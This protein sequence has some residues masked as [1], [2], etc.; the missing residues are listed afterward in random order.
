MSGP[1][2]A[3]R[4]LAKTAQLLGL[5]AKDLRTQ[6]D[7]GKTLA[8]VAEQQGVSRDD[9]IAS[10]KEGLAAGAPAG[11]STPAD[12]DLDTIAAN[13]ADGKRP[14]PPPSAGEARCNPEQAVASLAEV[15]GVDVNELLKQLRSGDHGSLLD[16]WQEYGA[17]V[18][19]GDL[20]GL[21]VDEVA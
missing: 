3:G 2:G 20:S 16:A 17:R 18:S 5:D 15:M 11:V 10:I 14:G 1:P 21:Q 8:Q 13:I 9:L 12:V 19:R 7:E 4:G 6:L